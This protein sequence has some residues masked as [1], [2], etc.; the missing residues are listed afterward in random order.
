M[1]A[2]KLDKF[3]L[4]FFI[5]LVVTIVLTTGG[6]VNGITGTTGAVTATTGGAL[7]NAACWASDIKVPSGM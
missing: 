7:Y 4:K 5:T 1:L 2:G 3:I 6:G